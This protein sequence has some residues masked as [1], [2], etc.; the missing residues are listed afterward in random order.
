[1]GRD[2]ASTSVQLLGERVLNERKSSVGAFDGCQVAAVAWALNTRAGQNAL[3]VLNGRKVQFI[4]VEIDVFSQQFKMKA[5]ASE[6]PTIGP[7]QL[8][9]VQDLIV[10][11]VC[12]KIIPDG[13]RIHIRTAFPR[14]ALSARGQ[15]CE[16][17][18]VADGG[19]PQQGIPI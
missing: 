14:S 10:A 19:M 17:T 6:V 18:Y 13:G 7:I 4:F 9:T 12:M 15:R 2:R 16:C 8:P 3:M 11:S 5:A 1:M